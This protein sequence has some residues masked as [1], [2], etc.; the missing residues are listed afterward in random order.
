MVN[1]HRQT[2]PP[3]DASE[4]ERLRKQVHQQR[5]TIAHLSDALVG[6]RRGAEALRAENRDLRIELEARRRRR[7]EPTARPVLRQAPS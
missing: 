2:L 4:N 7:R 5:V 3:R 1:N 6:M